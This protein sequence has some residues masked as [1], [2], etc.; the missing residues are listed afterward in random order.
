MYFYYH[1]FRRG[2]TIVLIKQEKNV[3]IKEASNTKK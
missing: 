3:R 2:T 1:I